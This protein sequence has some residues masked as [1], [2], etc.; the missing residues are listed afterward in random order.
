MNDAYTQ[1]IQNTLS[2]LYDNPS[3]RVA[4]LQDLQLAKQTIIDQQSVFRALGNDDRLKLI[5]SLEEGEK[6]ACELQVVL[7]APQSTVSTH[8]TILRK[9]GLVQRRR[10]GKWSYYRIADQAVLDLLNTAA[11]LPGEQ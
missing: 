4:E 7:D 6:C 5:A 10:K 11:S 8:L 9:A 3:N 1:T 2:K